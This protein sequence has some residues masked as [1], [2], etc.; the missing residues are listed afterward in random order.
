M[1][2]QANL[3]YVTAGNTIINGVSSKLSMFQVWVEV[4]TQ[5]MIRLYD[6]HE[7]CIP[8][9]PHTDLYQGEMATY[10]AEA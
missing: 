8:N 6:L 10:L 5:E 4:V 2:H 3:N 1:F 7:L 9:L